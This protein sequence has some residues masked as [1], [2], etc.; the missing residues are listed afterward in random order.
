MWVA[1]TW[2]AGIKVVHSDLRVA[3]LWR[4]P[5]AFSISSRSALEQSTCSSLSSSALRRCV[6]PH[7]PAACCSG[8]KHSDL[9]ALT[10]ADCSCT[11]QLLIC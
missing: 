7:P 6:L 8:P 4:Q 10:H 3:L 5:N 11:A 2:N 1:A 9:R